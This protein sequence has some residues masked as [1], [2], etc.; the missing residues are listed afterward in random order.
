[1][2]RIFGFISF[3]VLLLF[4]TSSAHGFN[5]FQ[6]DYNVKY[7]ILQNAN[8]HVSMDVVLTN[9][10][11]QYYASQYKIIVGF[12]DITNL[13]ASDSQ[14][15]IIP[16]VTKENKGEGIE[17]SFNDHPVG[18]G[19][20]LNFSISFDTDQI[21]QNLSSVWEIN[22]PGISSQNDFSTFNAT[23]SYPYSLGKPTFIKPLVSSESQ[24]TGSLYF[25]KEQL[26]SS[27]ISLAFG[28]SQNYSF[29]LTYDLE[30]PN[31]F[32]INTEIALPPST[33]YQDVSLLSLDPKPVNVTLDKDGNWLAQYYLKPSQR[34]RVEAT[35][36]TKVYL[37]PKNAT[38]SS[39]AMKQYLAPKTYWESQDPRI[40]QVASNL[41]TPGDIY[42][43]VV[44][45][46]N[47][48]FQRAIDNKPR[49]GAVKALENPNSAVCL[50][51]TDLFIALARAAGI[52]AREVDGFAYTQNSQQRP[53]SL[54]KDVL[55]A[56]PEYYDFD[57]KSW[58]MIDPTWGK[59]A[60]TDY[61]NVLDFDHIAFVVKGYNS[62]YP[63]P[64]GGYKFSANK[65]VKD[66]NIEIAG[67]SETLDKSTNTTVS[68]PSNIFPGLPIFG[69]VKVTNKG[70]AVSNASQLVV[71][72][73]FLSPKQQI[74]N[75]DPIPPYGF[76]E[77][78]IS[79]N[80][81]SFLTNRDATVKIANGNKTYAYTVRVSPFLINKWFLI[82]GIA[83]VGTIFIIFIVI[84][85]AWRLFIFK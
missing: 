37:N 69:S 34:L 45:T 50:E 31:L 76:L 17:L 61:F 60:G 9:L 41:K 52:P 36:E 68:L 44:K 72:S 67:S 84:Y 21:A 71:T 26:G 80:R 53:L 54:I 62:D 29:D 23:V 47:Y 83:I 48:D 19:N 66:V 49:L 30:N 55:H 15:R 64:A 46:L 38:L 25:T 8:T 35:G 75:L 20:K 57:K 65:N 4:F 11:E 39:D 78:P 73:D 77:I 18:L 14:G 22:I 33:N 82:G 74:L 51:F 3:F 43:Y 16:K 6:T 40:K 5:N 32:P 59:T 10:T 24:Q 85:A 81:T 63:I 70:N 28:D 27:G 58:I 79:F 42:E 12:S 7:D 1:M 13:Y 2:K 56:W